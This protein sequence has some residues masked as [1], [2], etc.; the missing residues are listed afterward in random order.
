MECLSY[1]EI[2]PLTETSNKTC[3]IYVACDIVM[4]S[5]IARAVSD[6][7]TEKITIFF[8]KYHF[9]NKLYRIVSHKYSNV[10]SRR[11]NS[12]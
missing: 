5:A 8:T 7:K 11:G 12:A 6:F 3:Y 1:D 10:K 4:N 2:G 9:K